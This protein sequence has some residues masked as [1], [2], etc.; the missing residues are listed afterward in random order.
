MKKLLFSILVGG[1]VLS[2]GYGTA[3]AGKNADTITK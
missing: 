3:L 1:L 2:L